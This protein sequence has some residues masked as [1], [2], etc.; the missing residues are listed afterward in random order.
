MTSSATSP[1]SEPD[2]SLLLARLEEP[3]VRTPTRIAIVGDPHLST[4]AHGTDRVFHRTEQRLRSVIEDVNGRDVDL[5]VFPGDLT[6]DGEPWNYERLDVLLEELEHPFV[7]TP[8]NHDL[9]KSGDDHRCPSPAAFAERYAEGR[10]PFQQS[11]G[12]LDLFVLNTAAGS[13]GPY[14]TT[15][16]GRICHEQLEW[17]DARL[18]DATVPVVV[19]H[20]NPIPLVRD[21]LCLTEPWRTFTLVGRDRL[22]IVLDDHD[23]PLVLSGHHHLPS[24]I[25]DDGLRQ[26]VTPAMATYPQAYCVLE[27]DA[28]GT[29]IWLHSHAGPQGRAEARTLA[30]EANPFRRTLLE[31]TEKTLEDAPV[32]YEGARSDLV[33]IDE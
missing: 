24:L 30:R 5:V 32:L 31:F 22:R 2:D 33:P 17:L 14:E 29:S 21:P 16:R 10:Y 25:D 3:S 18:A 7:A 12:D 19:S 13:N 11:V 26:L 1:F 23:V 20:H 4:Q 28:T 27:A 8:G 15:H 9:Q 6:K